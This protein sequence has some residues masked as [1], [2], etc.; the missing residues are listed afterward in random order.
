MMK[1]ADK[2]K[3]K[4]PKELYAFSVVKPVITLKETACPQQSSYRLE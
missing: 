3:A 2:A 4:G 1:S